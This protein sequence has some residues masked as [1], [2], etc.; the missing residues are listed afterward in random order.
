MFAREWCRLYG[1]IMSGYLKGRTALGDEGAVWLGVSL[2]TVNGGGDE[3]RG[4][5][6]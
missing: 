2:R 6:F 5:P 1:A 3:D 4:D